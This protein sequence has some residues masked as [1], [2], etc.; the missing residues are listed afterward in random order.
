MPRWTSASRGSAD[1]RSFLSTEAGPKPQL[2]GVGLCL[3]TSPET[4]LTQPDVS[5][6]GHEHIA[7]FQIPVDDLL[8]VQEGESFEHLAANHLNL[9][10]SEASVQ[11]WKQR[12]HGSLAKRS[13]QATSS[14]PP[15]RYKTYTSHQC[16]LG[17]Y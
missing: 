9:G 1:P 2:G 8:A 3:P 17:P 14:Q 15:A 10:L 7:G 13:M 6:K 16:A 4:P 5:L 11:L 12:E